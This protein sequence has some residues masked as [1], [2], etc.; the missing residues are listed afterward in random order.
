MKNK[1][2][3]NVFMNINFKFNRR[4]F[5]KGFLL[6]SCFLFTL[7]VS[8]QNQSEDCSIPTSLSLTRFSTTNYVQGGH[9]AIFFEPEGV[10]ELDNEFILE[11][12]DVD[13]SF[14]TSTEIS[15]K[16]DFY[17]P[18]LNGVIPTNIALGSNY[19]LRV[20][21]TAPFTSL[22]TDTFE[23]IS[24]TSPQLNPT[25]IDYFSNSP[26]T[27]GE[28]FIKCTNLEINDYFLG[29]KDRGQNEVTPSDA[30]G[31]KLKIINSLANSTTVR[32][33]YNNS[34]QELSLNSAG[35]FAI[36]S[37]LPV[38]HYLLEIDQ[39]QNE[40]DVNEYHNISGFI[41]HFNTNSTGIANTSSET[42]CVEDNVGFEVP[43]SSLQSNYPGSLYSI[44]YGDTDLSEPSTF[45]YYS[46]ARLINCNTLIHNYDT[47][48]CASVYQVENPANN[49]FYF[50]LNFQL[51][52]KG[53][54]DSNN[55]D[56][57]CEEH[58]PN[59]T[60]TQKL[61]NVSLKPSAAIDLEDII[62]ENSPI[63]ATDISTEGL[64]GFGTECSTNYDNVW[65]YLSPSDTSWVTV[66]T[67]DSFFS[68]WVDDINKTLTI[69]GFLT[70][71]NPGCWQVRLVIFNELGCVQTDT[72]E[73]TV[74]VEPA[75]VP[76]FTYS[77]S[78]DLCI[79]VTIN[80][81]NTS[82]TESVQPPA[83]GN[84]MYTWSVVPDETTPATADGFVLIDAD[85]DDTI[86]AENQTDININ[87]DQPGTYTVTLELE[88]ICG[89]ETFFQD[90]TVIGDP[91]VVF[92]PD[93]LEVCQ[94]FPADYTLDFSDTEIAPTYSE[95]PFTPEDY[96]W[97]VYEADGVTPATNYSFLDVNGE[98]LDFPQINFTA[99]GTYIIRVSVSGDCGG[100]ATDDFT[101][102]LKR[103]PVLT[104][105]VLTQTLCSEDST[106]LIDFTSDILGTTYKWEATTSD[107]ITGFPEGEQ[108]TASIPSL[109]LINSC[110]VTGVVTVAVTPFL[111][112]CAGDTVNL[113]FIVNPKPSIN[114]IDV[115][116]CSDEQFL[117][118]IENDCT[119]GDI[120]PEDTTYTW[121]VLSISG[122]VTGVA[123]NDN[124]TGYVNGTV[125]NTSAS[126][127]LIVYEVIP[128]SNEGC[129]GALFTV[130]VTI[131]PEPVVENQIT[132]VCS[133]V[134][135]DYVIIGD[136]SPQVASYTLISI[137]SNSLFG[138]GTNTSPATGLTANA[139]KDDV[140][141]NETSS[142]VDVVY[143]FIPI[144]DNVCE[145]DA[146]T[147]TVTVNPE[148]VVNTISDIE[149]CSGETVNT[150]VFS[151]TNIG[152]LITY[153]WQI[154][155]GI[156]LQPLFGSGDIPFFI[157]EN[158]SNIP[159]TATVTV[160]PTFT[161]NGLSCE[162][163]AETFQIIVNPKPSIND[164][165]VEICSEDTFSV[166][167]LNN[168]DGDVVPNGTVY[169]WQVLSPN[170]N[171]TGA[172]SGSGSII[173]QTLTNTSNSPQVVVYEVTP[174]SNAIGACEGA[175]FTIEVTVSPR[176]VLPN[177]N[178]EI[179]SGETFTYSPINNPP[180]DIVPIATTY[181]WT[182]V[183]NPN[184]NG[185]TNGT[186]QNLFEQINL[187][188]TSNIDQDVMYFVTASAGSCSSS[189]EIQLT[190]KA[191]PFIPY[192]SG[193]TDTRCSGDSF[194]I[195]PVN[196]IPDMN[197]IVPIN[198]TYTW[199]VIPNP[200]LIGWSDV[201]IPTGLISQQLFNTTNVNQSIEYIITPYSGVCEG[202]SFSAIIWIEPKPFIPNHIE[203]LCDG[204]SFIFSPVNGV[205]PDTST[206]VPDLTLYTWTVSDL[207]GGLVTGYSD[208]VD[209]P[210]LDTGILL[211]D[212][213]VVQTL[214]YTITPTYYVPSNPGVPRCIGDD[215]TL[216]VSLNPGVDANASI[217]NISC[218]Y[219]P[220]CGGSIELDPI[221]IGPFTYNWTYVGT[222]INA[223]SNPNLEDQFNLCPG[224]YTVEITDALN[225]VYTFNYSIVPPIPVSFNLLALVD[226]SCNNV[227]PNCD[228]YIEVDLNGGTAP[229][230]L[231]EWYTESIP[232]SANFDQLVATNSPILQNACE[233]NYVLKV[234]DANGCEFVSPTY[235]VN[236]TGSP[237]LVTEQLSNYNGFNVSCT[238]TNDG[239]IE[240]DVSG[241]SGS[242]SYLMTPGNLL[243]ADIT[244]PNLLEFSNLGAGDYTLT[245]T[246]TNCPLDIVLNYTLTAPQALVSSH[247]Q[248]SGPALCNGDTV[249]YNVAASGG[250]PPYTGTG[251]YTFTAGTYPI[252][253]TDANGC[254]TTETITVTEPTA[255]NVTAVVSQPIDCFAGIGEITITAI[256]GTT[257]YVGTG[258]VQVN[259]GEYFYTVTDANNCSFTNSII[260]T[261]PAQLTYTVDVVE[262]PT[263]S[264]DWSYTN[265]TICIIIAGGT[266]PVPLGPG[267]VNNGSG[268]WCLSNL[269]SGDYTI[270]VTDVNSC[271]SD[272]GNTIVTLTRPPVIDAFITSDINTD[273]SI[274]TISQ[275][276]YV[277][278]NGGTP[279][280]QFTWSGG[281]TCVPINAQCMETTVSGT[282]TVFIHDQ[283]SLANGCPPIE[284]DVMVD[285]PEIGDAFFDYTSPN[286]LLCNVLAINE[287]ILFNSLSTGD[288]VNITWD[289]GD[290]SPDVVGDFNPT[291][292][293]SQVGSYQVDL[294]VEYP[295]GCTETYTEV[296]QITKGYDIILPNAFT[297]N[298]DGLNDTIRPVTL[299]V[300]EMEL[301]VYDTWGSLI[302][303]EV[304]IDDNIKGW[305]GTIN[306]QSAE[307]GN[308]I[309][310]VKA[311]TYRGETID[312]NGPIT[313]IK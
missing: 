76:S 26:Y 218:S 187:S 77:P 119:V 251:N 84:P 13:G 171:I 96:L 261:E 199:E 147:V 190:V 289:F 70:Q 37:D 234:I 20:R 94:V 86:P 308:Y 62:C 30:G 255:L 238:T 229:Y 90:I 295:Y 293:Y 158:L 79:P 81:T 59:G 226:L 207:S 12:S 208:G 169:S 19:K 215:F 24:V 66:D 281:D 260:I 80:F 273:C 14:T 82:N 39:T 55:N 135:L 221:G 252:T 170:P 145:G 164:K 274:N 196:G 29:Y 200:N 17:L 302:Y 44:H 113:E 2:L 98:T 75:P 296:I 54:F 240:V 285:L 65:E 299:C 186:D 64:Y 313:L 202:P 177:Q 162:G 120:I 275:T 257:P 191:R 74:I 288:I 32:M 87:F 160:T 101:F 71:S 149:V 290:G 78:E 246:D 276:N 126:D 262:N 304:G 117:I 57:E 301:S 137:E 267:W 287:P 112:D 192:D 47:T 230:T 166:Q 309:I 61:V 138:L 203:T 5:V 7:V 51:F 241:G 263:C 152:G 127:V 100:G 148:P 228:G 201:N 95:S 270:D 174:I 31:I 129:L 60:G 300:K 284:V 151:T 180:L 242:F 110:N 243:D 142:P 85:T 28:N 176:P 184:I 312:I 217:T 277:F 43:I 4:S 298:G 219:S 185:E 225:C 269:S 109:S 224:D 264:P 52:S 237:I 291:H 178:F 97:E 130:T 282:Y 104:N 280:Y 197:T 259:A 294:T 105:T 165:T 11:L 157:S 146:F 63:I 173:S 68:G 102:I 245:I 168:I 72:A 216:T 154:N 258:V 15:R 253:I 286:S 181:T 49:K 89:V 140:W 204:D 144:G 248:T 125:T 212:S 33:F 16:S 103:E 106:N 35:Q 189:F 88:N 172:S 124:G 247:S 58:V 23:I 167:P 195:Q 8:S 45:E 27:G 50:Q 92:N 278:V 179:C 132:E 233:G 116:I 306:G 21:S 118:E 83:C 139:I 250:V 198:T 272:I 143:T 239:F 155:T 206:I 40:G 107:P 122:E 150:I 231:I 249:T 25:E 266:N 73:E 305:D 307:N 271:T 134:V 136:D 133:D 42:V 303:V 34:W 310:V 10:F 128:T 36:P 141:N 183:D 93:L 297:P 235:T 193:L 67:T 1:V 244:T 222:E 115:T 9:V 131:K 121:E 211:N 236:E 156:G 205:F 188:N 159:V 223:I 153:N 91:T 311:T 123:L 46:H 41:F 53:L 279:P 108:E 69:P 214:V 265:G 232:S 111:D 163:V 213:A 48:T 161:A 38:N 22:E 114:N 182:F 268:Q 3:K 256:G 56:F 283:E 227:S 220:L 99:Y 209:Q 194:V 175:T 292:I 210:F 254:T 18:A 6:I